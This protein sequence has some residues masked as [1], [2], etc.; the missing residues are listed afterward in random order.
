[1]DRAFSIIIEDTVGGA[2]V[3]CAGSVELVRRTSEWKR[4]PAELT[5]IAIQLRIAVVRSHTAP[6]A[7]LQLEGARR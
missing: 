4:R 7:Q 6:V 2:L 3:V 1:M 5:S